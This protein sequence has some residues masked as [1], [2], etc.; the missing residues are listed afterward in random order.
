M[1]VRLEL[2]LRQTIEN[3]GIIPR[4]LRSGI[5]N[6]I[7]GCDICAEVCPWNRFAQQARTGLLVARPE[8]AK[9]SLSEL[10]RLTPESFAA[11][12]K[13][14]AIKRLKLKG[15]LRNA[16]I[17][18]ANQRATECLPDLR[19]LAT[20]LEPVVRAH[21]IWA[22]RQL[23]PFVDLTVWQDRETDKAVLAEYDAPR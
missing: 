16:C 4:E 20:H 15:L 23:D 21:A 9:L 2:C 22:I 11:T 19:N 10:L 6:R 14:T 17:V 7:Y 3:K 5:G 8:L 13:G 18:A 12:F 1:P